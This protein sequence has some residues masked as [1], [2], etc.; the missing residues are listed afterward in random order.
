MRPAPPVKSRLLRFL[1]FGSLGKWRNAEDLHLIPAGG[2]ISL[3]GK[4]GALG[5]FAF[6]GPGGRTCTRT[7]RGLSSLPL[8]W[9]TPGGWKWRPRTDLHR[10]L[11]GQSRM[12]SLLE[13]QGCWKCGRAPRTRT[14]CF[15]FAGRWL[16]SS[17]R[18]RSENGLT[19]RTCTGTAAFTGRD[20]DY[21]IMVNIPSWG[22]IVPTT[23]WKDW[24]SMPVPPRLLRRERPLC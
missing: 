8:H 21:Y 12:L 16:D 24:H 11:P 17:P 2:T 22:R 14:G 13:L 20:A 1:S 9:A 5:R 4:P 10:H 23:G 18:A 3:A 15:G 7:G 19:N 6:H